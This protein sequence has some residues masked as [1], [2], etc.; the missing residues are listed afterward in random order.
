MGA[1]GKAQIGKNGFEDVMGA[2][3]VTARDTQ[4]TLASYLV[5]PD[6]GCMERV[7]ETGP[8]SRGL[9]LGTVVAFKDLKSQ[10][11]STAFSFPFPQSP[12]MKT[13]CRCC[14][15]GSLLCC[16]MCLWDWEV[17]VSLLGCGGC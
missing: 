15:G 4:C 7:Q 9:F 8:D 13:E 12:Q 17:A 11:G 14:L 5:V 2:P 1:S 3:S 6:S 16:R 10:A